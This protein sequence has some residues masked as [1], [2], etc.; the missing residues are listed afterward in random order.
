[1]NDPARFGSVGVG[2]VALFQVSTLASW[3]SIAYT[4]Y[5][6][7]DSYVGDPYGGGGDSAANPSVYHTN[8][9]SFQGHRCKVTF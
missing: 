6:G 4:S 5:F 3:T 9:G 2:M 8:L 1:M 7:C